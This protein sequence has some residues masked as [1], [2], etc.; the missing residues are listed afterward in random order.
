VAEYLRCDE[1]GHGCAAGEVG[2]SGLA[3][4]QKLTGMHDAGHTV[5]R[6]VH[7]TGSRGAIPRRTSKEEIPNRSLIW[8]CGGRVVPGVERSGGAVISWWTNPTKTWHYHQSVAW[9]ID[10]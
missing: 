2:E 5:D 6:D 1:I 7:A 10:M 4:R 9:S 8:W 3:W